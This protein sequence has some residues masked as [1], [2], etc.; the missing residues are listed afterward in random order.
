MSE[1]DISSSDMQHAHQT[2]E[3]KAHNID[4]RVEAI[5]NNLSQFHT[6]IMQKMQQG[7]ERIE[8][9]LHDFQKP[10][11]PGISEG[12]GRQTFEEK[13]HQAAFM[14]YMRTG[15]DAGLR[16]LETKDYSIDSSGA[17][18]GFLVSPMLFSTIQAQTNELSPMRNLANIV[19]ARAGSV[20]F[21]L[22]PDHYSAGWASETGARSET[23]T[24]LIRKVTIKAHDLYAMPKVTQRLLDD[25]LFNL[26]EW[27]SRRIGEKF[28]DAE[29]R[30]FVNGD[31]VD[32]PIGFLRKTHIDQESWSWGNIGYI[33]TG[34]ADGLPASN[35]F[36]V[37]VDTIY[38]LDTQYRSGAAWIMNS[39]TAAILRKVKDADG[40]YLWVDQGGSTQNPMLMGYKVVINEEMPDIGAGQT[41]IAFG[42]FM[43]GY[44]ILD[45]NSVRIL[46]DPYTAKPNV[47]FY[48]VKRVGGDVTDFNAIKLIKCLS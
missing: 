4:P 39:K 12:K 8:K 2:L 9:M 24:S 11:L 30:A 26:E 17:E 41:P 16:Q 14:D 20:E 25:N 10:D 23:S 44:T 40:R 35:T 5:T 45:V 33:K 15:Q 43:R 34:D 22:D 18:G 13:Q 36:D 3:H 7:E 46:R 31:G 28:S 21:L 29:N 42:N 47:F 27:I 32:K 48:A 19:T 38:A 6:N 1:Q 37:L